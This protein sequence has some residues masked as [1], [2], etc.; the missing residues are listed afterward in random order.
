MKKR[1][2]VFGNVFLSFDSKPVIMMSHL[3]RQHPGVEFIQTDPNENF[4]PHGEV[5]LIILDTVQ[6]IDRVMLLD[7]EDLAKIEKTPVSP[8]DYDLL[9]HLL[10]LKK[11]RKITR[12]RI[13]GV[14]QKAGQG[15]TLADVS[16]V[17]STLL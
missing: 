10:L 7:S 9:F 4:P 12:V 13:I 16:A 11:L 14:P 2:Y 6:G 15:D 1:I 8:H 5:D 3:Q 17:I